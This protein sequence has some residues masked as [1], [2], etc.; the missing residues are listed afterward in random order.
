MAAPPPVVGLP[1]GGAKESSRCHLLPP[2]LSVP[3]QPSG[4]EVGESLGHEKYR[5][6][7]KHYHKV[8]AALCASRLHADMLR[9]DLVAVRTALI[10]ALQEAAQTREDKA[11]V[12][13]KAIRQA[14]ATVL[15]I[16]QL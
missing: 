5:K 2:S 4:S 1:T 3:A 16:A 11:T 13:S 10:M 7:L 6:L 8:R 15:A 9:G 12:V 14:A